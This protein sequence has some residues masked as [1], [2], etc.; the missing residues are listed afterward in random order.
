ML[1]SQYFK[2]D[3]IFNLFLVKL[4]CYQSFRLFFDSQ[5]QP[6]YIR[7]I[8]AQFLNIIHEYFFLSDS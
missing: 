7:S 6:D 5:S 1:L 3:V 4:Y 2:K 8:T